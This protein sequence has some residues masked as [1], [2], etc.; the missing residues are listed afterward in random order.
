M[1]AK[2]ERKKAR[3]SEDGRHVLGWV[4]RGKELVRKRLGHQQ[5]LDAGRRLV[6]RKRD[7]EGESVSVGV[8]RV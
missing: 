7:R 8:L 6:A 3:S 2:K 4:E 5:V 1:V